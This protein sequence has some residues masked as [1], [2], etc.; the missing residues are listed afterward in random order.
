[1]IRILSVSSSR[2]DIGILFPVWRS[3]SSF[4]GVELH[5]LLTGMHLSEGAS[6]EVDL[7]T[8]VKVHFGGADLGGDSGSAAA[9]AMAS[10]ANATA[11]LVTAT[12]PNVML[13]VGDRLDMLPA[14]MASLPFYLPLV[15]LH[16]GEVTEGAVDNQI[17]HAISKLAHWHCVATNGAREFLLAIGENADRITVTG[18]PGLDMLQAAPRTSKADFLRS[19]GL[20]ES[21]DFWLV[22]VHAETNSSNPLLPI[23]AVLEALAARSAPV[24]FTAPNS[25]PGGSKIR[26]QIEEFCKTR[27]DVVFIDTLGSDL[28]PNAL[29]HA[30]L[31]LGNSSSGVI[32]AG[33][34]GLPV[35]NVGD[36]QLG[37]ESDA[38]VIDVPSEG[39]AIIATLD[40]LKSYPKRFNNQS[41]YGDG[42]SGPRVAQVLVE[43]SG[44]PNILQKTANIRKSISLA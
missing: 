1:M 17:R 11:D 2:A 6:T 32:E 5:L 23:Q 18:A 3:L 26:Q 42:K 34:F 8:S 19:T 22:T 16:G 21:A 44:F 12:K 13:V 33:L 4:S 36:R 30:S 20:P 29:R 9:A 28:Y 14:A 38:N 41:L 10:I 24:L 37:R 39:S 7:P 25:D 15:H 31:M 43:L 35:I 27:N 40:K